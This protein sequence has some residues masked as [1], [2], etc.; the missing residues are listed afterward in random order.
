MLVLGGAIVTPDSR[1]WI[2]KQVRHA[3]LWR[4]S[5]S[6]LPSDRARVSFAHQISQERK[7]VSEHEDAGTGFA[8]FPLQESALA[9]DCRVTTAE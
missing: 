2:P 7:V 8:L 9:P 4:A 1:C 3:L 5:A 6:F